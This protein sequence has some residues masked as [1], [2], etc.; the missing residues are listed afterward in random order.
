MFTK[1][2]EIRAE[3]AE[4]ATHVEGINQNYAVKLD[5]FKA[6]HMESSI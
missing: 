5:Q 2:S 4:L 3:Q 1:I 6:R